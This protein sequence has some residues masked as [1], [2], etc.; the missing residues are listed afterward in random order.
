M[1]EGPIVD[2]SHGEKA[3]WAQSGLN[4]GP[5]GGLPVFCLIL[6]WYLTWS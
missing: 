2:G 4:A 5:G 6:A 1:L 3:C